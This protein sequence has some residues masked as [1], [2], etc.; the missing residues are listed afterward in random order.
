MRMISGKPGET[1]AILDAGLDLLYSVRSEPSVIEH[2]EEQYAGMRNRRKLGPIALALFAVDSSIAP[3]ALLDAYGSA[4]KVVADRI[5]R[6]LLAC[7]P[8]DVRRHRDLLSALPPARRDSL[9]I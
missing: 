4:T 6:A 3:E 1:G 7:D 2:L 5:R 8:A 9:G